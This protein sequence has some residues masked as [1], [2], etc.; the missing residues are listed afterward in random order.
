MIK[1]EPTPAPILTFTVQ[2]ASGQ[3]EGQDGCFLPLIVNTWEDIP[4]LVL[5]E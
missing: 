1:W 2:V 3:V 5:T 4:S